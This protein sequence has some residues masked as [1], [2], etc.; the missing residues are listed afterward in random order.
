M[1]R[2]RTA[3][4]ML[5]VMSLMI[6]LVACQTPSGRTAGEVVDDSTI[7]SKVKALLL[8]DN[9]TAGWA[10]DVDVDQGEVVMTGAVDTYAQKA[11]ASEIAKSVHGVKRVVNLLKLKQ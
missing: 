8:E 3:M 2:R 5:I 10:I 9:L 6:G 1:H 11:R 7:F 4:L